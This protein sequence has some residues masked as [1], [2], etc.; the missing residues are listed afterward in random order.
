MIGK[1]LRRIR[2]ENDYSQE[3][4]GKLSDISRSSISDYEREYS[5]PDF[6]TIEK[7]ANACNYEIQFK[8]KKNGEIL[9]S[10]NIERK[11]I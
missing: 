1:I 4:V 11:E 9:T 7:I 8:N 10:K 5:H 6:Y 2:R 3:D